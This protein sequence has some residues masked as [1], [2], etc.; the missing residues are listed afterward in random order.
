MK[1]FSQLQFARNIVLTGLCLFL[2]PGCVAKRDKY[3]VPA[4]NLPAQFAKAPAVASD[5]HALNTLPPSSASSL[6]LN[7]ELTEWWRLLGS[8]ELNDLMDRALANNPDLRIS[9]LRI[10]QS[11]A[12]LSQAGA[13]KAPTISMPIQSSTTYPE[14]GAGRGNANGNN[15][16]RA[17]NQIS[18]KGDWRP[19]I[20]GETASLYEAAELQLL[21]ATY[22]RD[23]MQRNVVAN[24]AV[25]YIEYLSLNDRLRVARE[26]EKSLGEM[27]ASVDGRLQV[28]DATITEMEQ[29]KAAIYSVKATIPVLEQ[30]REV[31]IN[32]LAALLGSA[33]VELKLSRHGLNSVKFPQALPDMPSA[34]LLRRPDV[35]AMESRLLSA[36]ADIDVARARIL[37][38]LDLTAQAGYGSMYMSQLFLPQALFW[39]TIANLSVNIFDGGKRSKE[40]EFARAVHE[41]LVETYVRVIYDAVRE[42]D[43]SLSAL[44]YTGKRLEAQDL[45][46][47]SSLRAWNYSQEAF[48]A[49]AVDY[50]VLL[51][52]Q[53]TYQRNLDDWYSVRMDR[54]RSLVNLFSAL[55]GGVS[56]DNVMPEESARPAPPV[57]KNNQAGSGLAT[58]NKTHEIDWAGEVLRDGATHWLVE[59]SGVYDRGA[60]LPA[61]RDLNNRFPHQMES[62]A[63][64]PQRQGQV[65]VAAKER[66]SWY[67]LYIANLPDKEMANKLCAAL[68]AEQQRCVVVS[69]KSFDGPVSPSAAEQFEKYSAK[70]GKPAKTATG[71]SSD[72]NNLENHPSATRLNTALSPPPQVKKQADGVDWSDEQF[73]LVEMSDVYDRSAIVAAWRNLLTQFPAQMK[74]QTILPRRQSRLSDA[75]KEHTPFYQLYISSFPE[76]QAAE[77]FCSML[78]AGQQRCGVVPSQSL[79]RSDD[80]VAPSTSEPPAPPSAG[81]AAGATVKT[82]GE[83]QAISPHTGQETQAPAK[84][85]VIPA[86]ESM[87]TEDVE[88]ARLKAEKKALIEEEQKERLAPKGHIATTDVMEESK[89]GM[90]NT[91]A[92]TDAHMAAETDPA[93]LKAEQL[94]RVKAEKQAAKKAAAEATRLKAEQEARAA[95]K[96]EVARLKTEQEALLASEEKARQDEEEK[97]K[98]STKAT[99]SKTS[100]EGM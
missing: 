56:V 90:A 53:R 57:F 51:D 12:R 78:R 3:D 74:N 65:K 85:K 38:P 32:R 91:K 52:T 44:N 25:A 84:E 98:V 30:Q 18:L 23:D 58:E 41:E 99:A 35:R 7:A 42:V 37:P 34:L 87:T 69:S 1:D 88:I 22:Q 54:Y 45:A 46:A 17:T 68:G 94:S 15:T 76:K 86:E 70:T 47:D 63:L 61:W 75:G 67:R 62:L 83:T 36:D 97:T 21:R 64:L 2:L 5:S 66:A 89:V 13:D 59:L 16:A 71:T 50:L 48:M 40:V 80:Y 92:A 96:A 26:T 81:A 93:K 9:S 73:W 43:D 49:G 8:Q 31:V 77:E 29:Q 100:P 28:G 24:V 19:D 55:G 72:K 39:N 4:L 10:A 11:K 82:V 20:W 79:G 33:P 60:V 95:A 14:F 27:L 6:R